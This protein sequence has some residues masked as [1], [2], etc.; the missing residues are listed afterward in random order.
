MAL[1]GGKGKLYKHYLAADLAEEQ[2]AS[3]QLSLS[4]LE[5]LIESLTGD[6]NLLEEE[7]TTMGLHLQVSGLQADGAAGESE[8][9]LDH[10]ASG[11]SKRKNL[12]MLSPQQSAALSVDT[13]LEIANAEME[14]LKQEKEEELKQMERQ[15]DH[16]R[17]CMEEAELRIQETRKDM[18]EFRRDIVGSK[19]VEAE[20]IQRYLEERIKLKETHIQKLQTK[21]TTLKAQIAKCEAQVK[22][23]TD[24][25]DALHAIDFDQLKI[26]NQQFLERIEQKNKELVKLKLTTGNTVQAMNAL[27]EKLAKITAEQQWLKKEIRQREEHLA[28]LNEDS[29]LVHHE[30]SRAEGKNKQLKA[31]HEA[32]KVPK[33]EE[34]IQQKAEEYE[35]QKALDN[36]KRKVEI[37]E[38][39][40]KL[41]VQQLLKQQR[42]TQISPQAT[43]RTTYLS[44]RSGA[45]TAG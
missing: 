27:T 15:M 34:Y 45:M 17:A 20:K 44:G 43:A 25:G 23:R 13:K 26:E 16:F 37:A 1:K 33:V 36:W 31:Q 28:K 35:L 22:Q 42:S 12:R 29:Q 30:K 7:T 3:D 21:T 40:K 38:G 14:R 5:E 19:K 8:S 24:M 41:L 39:Q 32:V 9:D 11:T 4:D 2:V 10:Q 6:V 18:Y